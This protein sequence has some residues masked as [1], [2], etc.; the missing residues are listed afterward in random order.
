MTLF[1][2]NTSLIKW[3]LLVLL[4]TLITMPTHAKDK[5]EWP[6]DLTCVIGKF[7]IQWHLTG[8]PKT[9]WYRPVSGR[10][11]LLL[12]Y[13]KK[14]DFGKKNFFIKNIY[15][16]K[17]SIWFSHKQRLSGLLGTQINR[18]SL[19]VHTQGPNMSGQCHLGL[20]EFNKRF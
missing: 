9:S 2:S 4:L 3:A 16:E 5:V 12:L 13:V 7:V 20:K 15:V 6:I 18:H 1:L 11:G 14:K 8:E 10:G 17:D 19:G